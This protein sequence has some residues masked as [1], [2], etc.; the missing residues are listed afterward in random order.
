M[1]RHT[2]IPQY[3]FTACTS[4]CIMKSHMNLGMS[5]S[6]PSFVLI[7]FPFSCLCVLSVFLSPFL[8]ASPLRY[9]S[10]SRTKLQ[11]DSSLSITMLQRFI[12]S[13][14]SVCVS[15]HIRICLKLPGCCVVWRMI[16]VTSFAKRCVFGRCSVRISVGTRTVSLSVLW[17]FT[18]PPGTVLQN[19]PRLLRSKFFGIALIGFRCQ[20]LVCA[21]RVAYFA[22]WQSLDTPSVTVHTPYFTN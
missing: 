3:V 8:P 11:S 13:S 15:K 18:S 17:L 10:I 12:Q 4:T 21:Y 20:A 5:I 6:I 1:W 22:N 16:N 9:D 19:G 7:S 14:S 2:T